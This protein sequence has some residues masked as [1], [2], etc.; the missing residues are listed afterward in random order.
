MF[1]TSDSFTQIIFESKGLGVLVALGVLFVFGVLVGLGVLFAFGGL[2]GL[3]VFCG[4][5]SGVSVVRGAIGVAVDV[6]VLMDCSLCGGGSRIR[7]SRKSVD[8]M[9]SH[10]TGAQNHHSRT[11]LITSNGHINIENAE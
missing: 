7:L 9:K 11:S 3:G 10:R 4:L 5:D 6:A 1:S 2:V 8:M